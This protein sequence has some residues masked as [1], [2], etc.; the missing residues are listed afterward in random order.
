MRGTLLLAAAAFST[1]AFVQG[2]PSQAEIEVTN[3]VDAFFA[4]LRS[5][6]KTALA[7][8]MVP[9][10]VIFI[11]D[12][13]DPANPSITVRTVAEH[14]E[15]WKNSPTGTDEHMSYESVL[16]DGTMAHVWGSYAFL[17]NGETT[18]CGV[19]SMSLNKT[20]DGWKISN[21][22]FT[23]TA[24]DECYALGAPMHIKTIPEEARP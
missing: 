10:G 3:A 2:Q 14:V 4:A 13:R 5:D 1:P 9:E 16:I 17:L 12:R 11:H 7:R 15:G 20:A 6:D 23:M 24:L 18:H 19:N 8:T 22:S 21:T